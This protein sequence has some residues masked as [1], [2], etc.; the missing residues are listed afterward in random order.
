MNSGS[1]FM[2][3][4]SLRPKV[5]LHGEEA[6]QKRMNRLSQAA[7]KGFKNSMTP[8]ASYSTDKL[9]HNANNAPLINAAMKNKDITGGESRSSSVS[10]PPMAPRRFES[11]AVQN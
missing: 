5:V 2:S 1:P 4:I 10:S 8:W 11:L 7:A 9:P 3:D 6:I